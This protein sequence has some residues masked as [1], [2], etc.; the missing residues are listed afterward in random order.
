[1]TCSIFF[2]F[3]RNEPDFFLDFGGP[4]TRKRNTDHINTRSPRTLSLSTPGLGPLV[5]VCVCVYVGRWGLAHK[6]HRLGGGLALLFT[7]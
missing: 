5:C 3:L 7:A 4:S 2:F 1:M 6:E